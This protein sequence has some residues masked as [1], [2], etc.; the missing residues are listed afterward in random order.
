MFII[1]GYGLSTIS[2]PFFMFSSGL[3]DA[4]VVR[5]TD[6]MGKGIRTAPRDALIADSVSVSISGKA[7]GIHGTIDRWVS[8]VGPIVAFAILQFM[9][10]QAVFLL[11]LIPDVIAVTILVFFVKKVAT[12]KTA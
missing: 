1:I 10:I 3:F 2:K 11:S 12:K 9:D 8:I 5:A 4:F 7:F 6:R